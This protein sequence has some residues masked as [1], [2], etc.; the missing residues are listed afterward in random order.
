MKHLLIIGARGF[1][2]AVYDLAIAM[3]QY[4]KEF[5]IKG[6]LDDK[7][8]ALEGYDNYPPI[9]GTVESYEIHSDDVFICALGDVH[10]KKHYAELILNRGG[11]FISIV[12]PSAHIGRNVQIGKGCI[13]AGNVWLDSDSKLGDFVTIQV[14]AL[15]GHDVM[16]SDWTMIDSMCFLGGFVKIDELVTIHTHSSIIPHLTIGAESTVNVSSS[17]IRNVKAGSVV[18]GNPAR[19]L[20]IPKQN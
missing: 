6:F 19:E 3:S 18:M 16:V 4:Q 7:A 17:V 20:I 11:Q 10:Y 12:H 1:G 2:R 5:D 8:D 13:V 9:V 15:I 14:G